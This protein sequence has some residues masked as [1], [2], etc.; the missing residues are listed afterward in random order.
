MTRDVE[1]LDHVSGKLVA[2]AAKAAKN[3]NDAVVMK[4]FDDLVNEV[5]RINKRIE[6]AKK[7]EKELQEN[8]RR[9]QEAL[10]KLLDAAKRKDVDEAVRNAKEMSE[11]IKKQVI[12]HEIQ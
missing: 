5:R 2:V 10:K 9:L 12:F 3:P 1:A 4:E 6:D 8:A 7:I 11:N